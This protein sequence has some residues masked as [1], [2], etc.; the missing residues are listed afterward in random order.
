[1]QYSLLKKEPHSETP[2]SGFTV[3]ETHHV[4]S[5]MLFCFGLEVLFLCNISKEW[6]YAYLVLFFFLSFFQTAIALHES[7]GIDI[8]IALVLN[9]VNP[10]GRQRMDLGLEL[11]VCANFANWRLNPLLNDVR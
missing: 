10:L 9:D 5:C 7:N 4:L 6:F 3:L 2:L 8:V 11:K 1:M